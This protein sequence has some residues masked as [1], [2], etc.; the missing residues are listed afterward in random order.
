MITFEETA[1]GK[2]VSIIS[3]IDEGLHR[4][5]YV[6]SPSGRAALA[7]E[8]PSEIVDEVMAVWGDTPTVP[9]DRPEPPF[10]PTTVQQIADLKQQ[11]EATDYQII[12]CSECQ[13]AGQPI[14]YDVETLHTERQALRDQINKLEA[15]P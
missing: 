1:I 7:A 15:M 5:G 3:E 2:A 11:L 6:N 4:I 8:Q 10:V 13:L 14:P 9:D 12:K